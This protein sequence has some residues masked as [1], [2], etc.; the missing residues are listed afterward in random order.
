MTITTVKPSLEAF[1]VD[2]QGF[3]RQKINRSNMPG[4]MHDDLVQE[5][6]LLIVKRYHQ[7]NPEFAP[8]TWL[9]KVIATVISHAATAKSRKKRGSGHVTTMSIFQEDGSVIDSHDIYA[10]RWGSNPAANEIKRE[11]ISEL[12]KQVSRLSPQDQSLLFASQRRG[13][14]ANYCKA[15]DQSRSNADRRLAELKERL[16]Q[17]LG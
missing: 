1:L 5:V 4:S 13:G 7:Y 16:S 12:K 8:T 14:V 9:A 11:A 6:N 2:N 10:S 3:I 15:W 17:L